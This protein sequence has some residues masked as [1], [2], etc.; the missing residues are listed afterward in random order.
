MKGSRSLL[1]AGIISSLAGCGGGTDGVME[2]IPAPRSW[3]ERTTEERRQKDE[4]FKT[5]PASPLL[6]GD[7]PTFRGL[8]Y[9]PPDPS[10]RFVGRL[11]VNERPE[12][13]T[14]LTTSGKPRPCEKYGEVRFLLQGTECT[15]Q[16]YRLLDTE[17]LPGVSRLFLPF[18]DGTTGKETYVAGRYVSLEGPQDGPFLL[19]FN[20]ASNPWC[21]YGAP[22]RFACPVAPAENRLPVRVEAGERAFKETRGRG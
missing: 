3:A 16:V 2:P 15:L 20:R 21:A 4:Q 1:A 18:T 9:W 19:D 17:P 8:S 11:H 12:R 5:D 6:P 7:L 22:D 13:F 14:I 10:Y